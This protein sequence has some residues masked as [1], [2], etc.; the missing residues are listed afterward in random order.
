MALPKSYSWMPG[1]KPPKLLACAAC[2]PPRYVAISRAHKEDRMPQLLVRHATQDNSPVTLLPNFEEVVSALRIKDPNQLLGPIA[3]RLRTYGI[4]APDGMSGGTALGG[5]Q[6]VDKLHDA[7][8]TFIDER[9]LCR[10]CAR[11]E[12]QTLKQDGRVLECCMGCGH[13]RPAPF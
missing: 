9:V 1:V 12:L 3:V 7:L 6:S 13:T 10:E 4:G 8:R 2:E 11:P 5:H